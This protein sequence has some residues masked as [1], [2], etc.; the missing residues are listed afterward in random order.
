MPVA[1]CT[2]SVVP[3]TRAALFALFEKKQWNKLHHLTVLQNDP[4]AK[5]LLD[6]LNCLSRKQIQHEFT[7]WRRHLVLKPVDLVMPQM[8]TN[9]DDRVG[10]VPQLPQRTLDAVIH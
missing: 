2:S 4:E 10:S 7:H 6:E 8:I 9:V 3:G 1:V 5:F